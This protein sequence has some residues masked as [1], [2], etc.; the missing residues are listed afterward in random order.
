LKTPF[1][2]IRERIEKTLKQWKDRGNTQ[3]K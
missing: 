1:P 2:K 3:N